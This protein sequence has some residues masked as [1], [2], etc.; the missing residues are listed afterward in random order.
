[1]TL[2]LYRLPD[3]RS[4]L[5]VQRN[6]ESSLKAKGFQV[7]FYVRHGQL[8]LLQAAARQRGHAIRPGRL[9]AGLRRP[10]SGR[11]EQPRA[12]YVRNYFSMSGRYLLAQ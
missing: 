12:T 1:M 5:E 8:P 7:L 6:Y 4:L 10:P 2:Y 9:C 11:A 3:D